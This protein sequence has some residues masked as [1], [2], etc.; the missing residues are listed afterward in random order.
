MVGLLTQSFNKIH[1]H[2]H[3]RTL[4]EIGLT[5]KLEALLY[6]VEQRKKE[7]IKQAYETVFSLLLASNGKKKH[8]RTYKVNSC[9]SMKDW[10]YC[11]GSY[12]G[13]EARKLNKVGA[14]RSVSRLLT[15][16]KWDW[17]DKNERKKKGTKMKISLDAKTHI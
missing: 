14:P 8:R 2:A 16:G 12:E 9:H 11:N 7:K 10:I 6:Y 5:W 13:V 1:N 17:Q 15:P 4:V 3:R